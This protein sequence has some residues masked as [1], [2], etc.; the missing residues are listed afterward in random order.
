MT[1]LSTRGQAP[2]IS[3]RAAVTAGLAPDG[4]LYVPEAMP[5]IDLASGPAPLR[6]ETDIQTIARAVVGAFGGNDTGAAVDAAFSWPLPLIDIGR[7]TAVLEL[8]WGPSAAFKD[9][10]A[11]FLGAYM[12]EQRSQRLAVLV[13]TSGDTGGAVAAAFHG[14]P[15]TDVYVLYPKGRVSAR[16]EQQLTCWGDNVT[17]IA[18]RGTF[19]SCQRLVKQA[20]GD[21][22]FTRDRAL[23]SA[24]SINI[25]RLLPQVAYHAVASLHY[26]QRHGQE[27][28]FIVP[29]GNVGNALACLW[30]QEMGFPI[31]EVVLVTNANRTILDYR[32]TGTWQPR[33]AIAT[34]ANAMDVG[35]PSNMERLFHLM[36]EAERFAASIPVFSV[37]DETIRRVIADGER[38]W[39]RVFD[40]HTACAMAAR[41]QLSRGHW[42]V[43]ATAHPA[44]FETVVEPLVGHAVELPP[45]LAELMDRPTEHQEIAPDLDELR[46][47][48]C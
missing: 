12:S 20:F 37:A 23:T 45:A 41:E 31:R 29:T 2:T 27:A 17:A 33:D 26:L 24:N 1:F 16:Q 10:G 7:D 19:D 6:R 9:F 36:P 46:L 14:K 5:R 44:K 13:A 32:D 38:D 21:P 30:A 15:D 25:G 8:Y 47:L 4:G 40:P 11:Q 42:V 39:G 43:A 22:A 35:A 34:L 28:G 18:V 3:L 48:A